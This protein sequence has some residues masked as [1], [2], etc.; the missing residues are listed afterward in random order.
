[1]YDAVI[2]A[3]HLKGLAASS[4]EETKTEENKN[5]VAQFV[6]IVISVFVPLMGL[7]CACGMLKGICAAAGGTM[8]GAAAV[9]GTANAGKV[10]LVKNGDQVKPDLEVTG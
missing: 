3:G 5:I 6:S 7:L 9:N 1:M 4:E 2:K 10:M 8:K